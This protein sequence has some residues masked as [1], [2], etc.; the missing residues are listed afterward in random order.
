MC[1][2]EHLHVRVHAQVYNHTLQRYVHTHNNLAISLS[3]DTGY[4]DCIGCFSYF[5]RN[6]QFLLSV[7]IKVNI[8]KRRSSS[9]LTPNKK[10]VMYYTCNICISN[11]HKFFFLKKRNSFTVAPICFIRVFCR[12]HDTKLLIFLF[13][14]SF[15]SLNDST[16]SVVVTS[17]REINWYMTC[18]TN[19]W[20]GEDMTLRWHFIRSHCP[21]PSW[22]HQAT[23]VLFK[24]HLFD[25]T[26]TNRKKVS[27]LDHPS[28]P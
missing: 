1:V 19:P 9:K 3:K 24:D 11:F 22:N 18:Y 27:P 10:T 7:S 14:F 13:V 4:R 2:Y 23:G 16:S 25:W 21:T 5:L 12:F 28:P 6:F 20:H 17:L 26:Y 15:C 8:S